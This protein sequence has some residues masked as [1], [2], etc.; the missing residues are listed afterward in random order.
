[1]KIFLISFSLALFGL[2]CQNKNKTVVDRIIYNAHIITMDDSLQEAEVMVV[3]D[4][5]I[6]AIGNKSILEK[7]T[8]RRG[9]M[10]DLKGQFVYPGLIDAH[11]HFYGYAKTLLTCNLVGTKS[12]DDALNRLD[13]FVKNNP[14]A[15]IQGRGW[16]QNDWAVEEYPNNDSL[17][18]RYPNTPVILKR[19]DG[20]AAICNNKAL[21]IAGILPEQNSQIKI[22]LLS[23]IKQSEGG[24][25]ILKNGIPTGILID[26]AVDLV[27][28]HVTEPSQKE[29]VK[30]LQ[31]AEKECY[32]FGLTTLADAGLDLKE[33]L[34]LDS[35]SKQKL[36][37][38]YLYL[39]L[40]PNQSG[41]N[42]AQKNGILENNNT[43]IGS[44]KLYAD[45]AL[46][47][48]GAKMK[49][50]YCDQRMHAGML[51]NSPKYYEN[52]CNTVFNKT[53]YQV[54]THCIG[55][56][57]NKLILD[58]YGKLLK[59]DDDRRWRIEHAQILDPNDFYLFGK[60]GIIPSVQPTHASSDAPWVKDRIC[61]DRMA[62]AYA[63]KTLLKQNGYIPLGT[64]FPVEY[65]NPFY[66]FYSAVFRQ[67]ANIPSQAAFLPQESLSPLEALKGMTIWAAKACKLEHRK[68]SLE[69]GK[70]ADFVVMDKN[71]LKAQKDDVLKTKV[72]STYRAGN[73][74]Y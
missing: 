29:L 53:K 73:K 9:N 30:A 47:S 10:Q 6:L 56:S 67:N 26:H 34:F 58:L 32:G 39:M 38:I 18:N 62:G 43:Y 3:K 21:E 17:N 28:K 66:T 15:W 65:I 35:I 8:C 41:L 50:D 1:M 27:Q 60:F 42:Y 31:N 57:A 7:Y 13:T 19:I 23:S 55:D 68:G 33:C 37:S 69:T 44:F 70:D 54:N 63:Y 71:L 48:R 2:A 40:N 25:I 51:M 22:L 45:G 16:D 52:F 20:H 46:G 61:D 72:L 49:R 12:W 14:S 64:D 11:C 24:E 59:P 74:V 5:K 36:T 4:G